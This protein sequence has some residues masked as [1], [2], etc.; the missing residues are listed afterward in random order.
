MST[1]LNAEACSPNISLSAW[2]GYLASTAYWS[3]VSQSFV[4]RGP[5]LIVKGFQRTTVRNKWQNNHYMIGKTILGRE[6]ISTH[7]THPVLLLF[8]QTSASGGR[9]RLFGDCQMSPAHCWRNSWSRGYIQTNYTFNA[10]HHLIQTV[11]LQHY[12][13]ISK[14]SSRTDSMVSLRCSQQS[15]KSWICESYHPHTQPI[16]PSAQPSPSGP[17]WKHL[18]AFFVNIRIEMQ[19]YGGIWVWFIR[20]LQ[21]ACP[22]QD[23]LVRIKGCTIWKRSIGH[24]SLTLSFSRDDCL[25]GASLMKTEA[26]LMLNDV[27]MPFEYALILTSVNHLLLLF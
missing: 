22:Q 4:T 5:F 17:T 12:L 19:I 3:R 10:P 18:Y 14:P 2:L 16:K 24:L 13:N 9:T 21:C 6:R 27:F 1:R 7:S 26:Y 25:I 15:H 20:L 23:F 11:Y 8:W